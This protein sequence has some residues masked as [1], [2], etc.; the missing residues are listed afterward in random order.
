MEPRLKAQLATAARR[1]REAERPVRILRTLA[2]SP[3]VKSR[4][5]SQ[6][7]ESLPVVSYPP[8]TVLD[9]VLRKVD[10]A[11]SDLDGEGTETTWL[12]RQAEAITRAARMLAAI[13]TPDFLTHGRK[14]YG[15][16]EDTQRD[17][18]T[19][20][21]DL[22]RHV[23]RFAAEIADLDLGAPAVACHMASHVAERMREAV[24]ER[25]AAA[26]P[27]IVIVD[28]L[29]A[30]ALA[31][32][33]A[34]RIRRDARFT[35]K[36]LEQLVHHEAYVHVCTSLNGRLQTDLPILAAGHAGTTSTQEGL[37]VFAEFLS[38][39]MEPDR[40]RRL[41][42]RVLGIQMSIEGA[43]FIEVYR[44]FEERTA[45]PEQAFENAR[46]VF[47]GGM[48][49]G[50]APFTK[51]GVYLGGLLRVTNFLR[52]AVAE[53]RAD[54]ILLLFCG[55]L[56]IEDL[57]ALSHLT[58]AGLCLPPRYLPPW[59]EDRRFLVAQ[60]AFSRF[61]NRVDLNAVRDSYRRL[62][63]AVV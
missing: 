50:G 58:R 28:Q 52:T 21:L 29:S 33:K 34:I 45:N 22:A 14:L 39:A 55:K 13:E 47:R 7:G 36:D 40:F 53:R 12:R 61:L 42:D 26:A 63:E 4:F 24:D 27:E 59:I 31:G 56:D 1:L 11:L 62:L 37:A 60:L 49:G 48:L 6:G 51:D 35:D 20:T 43:D 10:E 23:D 32:P 57:P 44:F 16:P 17:G 25:F 9:E 46:R 3:A 15:V 8:F 38:G 18:V 54:C 41:A 30:N 19:T 2:W 5:L